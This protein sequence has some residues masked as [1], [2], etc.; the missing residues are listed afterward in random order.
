MNYRQGL[1]ALLSFFFTMTLAQ[2]AAFSNKEAVA[3]LKE[4]LV[5]G[6]E[7]AVT[8]LGTQDGFLGNG[9]VRISLPESLQPIETLGRTLGLGK[10]MDELVTT[11]NRAA[12]SA[13]TEAKPLLVQSV[14]NM[15]VK[16][17]Y[18]ILSGP[19]DAATQYFRKTTS[20]QLTEKIRPLVHKATARLKLSEKYDKLAGKAA[21]LNLIDANE[22]NL[23]TY[24]TQKTLDGLFLMIA[25]QEQQ[26]RANPIETGSKLLQKVF[27][28]L[29]R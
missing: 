29:G 1:F 20:V 17:A 8:T 19:Q 2:A 16:D 26:I 28:A 11:M 14:K 13:V 5:R 27:G 4:A 22:A 18:D 6:A 3:G 23:D 10:Q 9:K 12:E 21:K 25:E 15:S 7:H 24:V